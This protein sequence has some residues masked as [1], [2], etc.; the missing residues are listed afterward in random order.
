MKTDSVMT[1]N[2]RTGQRGS[3]LGEHVTDCCRTRSTR[4]LDQFSRFGTLWLAAER[5][6]LLHDAIDRYILS[7]GRSA[8]N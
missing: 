3:V 6:R 4:H 8:V 7:A 5:R 2:M 1:K